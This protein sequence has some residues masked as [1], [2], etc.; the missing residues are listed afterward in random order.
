M[1]TKR[2]RWVSSMAVLVAILVCIGAQATLAQSYDPD[3]GIPKPTLLEKRLEKLGRGLS[4]ILFGWAEIPL[5]F[6]SKMKEGKGL[7]YLVGAV[8]VIGTAKAIIRTGTGVVEVF[9]FGTT[10][11]DVNY[12][13]IL[14][15]EYIF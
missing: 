14:E 7:A 15:P 1:I 12:E 4:N 10:K 13:A 6:D 11:P 3:Q 8:P 2:K 9:T 5:T